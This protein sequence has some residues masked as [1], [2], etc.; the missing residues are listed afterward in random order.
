MSTRV[1][2]EK[3]GAMRG[4]RYPLSDKVANPEAWLER[5]MVRKQVLLGWQ[6]IREGLV[7]TFKAGRVRHIVSGVRHTL[8]D[9]DGR[10]VVEVLC[11]LENFPVFNWKSD[12]RVSR[13]PAVLLGPDQV[14]Y[15][16]L[17]KNCEMKVKKMLRGK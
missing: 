10:P 14:D 3:I 16:K 15:F 7:K 11:L 1:A 6:P 12:Q 8:S 5:W 13:T 17:C 4:Y 9:G 2:E